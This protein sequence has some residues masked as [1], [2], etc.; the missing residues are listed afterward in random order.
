MNP[1]AWLQSP[2]SCPLR[3]DSQGPPTALV[4]SMGFTRALLAPQTWQLLSLQVPVA[5]EGDLPQKIGLLIPILPSP[6]PSILSHSGQP[7][8]ARASRIC[9]GLNQ[10]FGANSVEG[11][12]QS[13]KSFWISMCPDL[14]IY[15][16]RVDSCTGNQSDALDSFT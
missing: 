10:G 15:G 9:E 5:W 13:G 6:T 12:N 4:T 16:L 3:S 1:G 14:G 11:Q 8:P 7:N 2:T